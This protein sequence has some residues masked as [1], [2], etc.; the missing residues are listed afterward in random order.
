M[1][2]QVIESEEGIPILGEVIFTG[3]VVF[4][5][6]GPG[7][8]IGFAPGQNCFDAASASGIDSYPYQ[9]TTTTTTTTTATTTTTT[10]PTATT[11]TTTTTTATTTTAT[12][13]PRPRPRPLHHLVRHLLQLELYRPAT[14]PALEPATPLALL[15]AL[16]S[17]LFLAAV[18]LVVWRKMKR[19]WLI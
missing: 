2:I 3:R 12:T 1:P 11:T 16:L 14:T 8:R 6:R 13:T 9:K 19:P 17:W 15:S 10:T 7:Q 5:D 4:F 18:A